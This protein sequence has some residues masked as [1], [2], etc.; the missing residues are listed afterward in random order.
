[1]NKISVIIPVYNERMALGYFIPHLIETLQ[2]MNI[3]SECIVVD[4]NS[5]DGSSDMLKIAVCGF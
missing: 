2:E 1:M 5:N 3:V 4:D